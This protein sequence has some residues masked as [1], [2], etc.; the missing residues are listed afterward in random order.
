MGDSLQ[1]SA[2]YCHH[3]ADSRSGL[4]SANSWRLRA[5][6]ACQG[7]DRSSRTR[8]RFSRQQAPV[9]DELNTANIAGLLP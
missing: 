7:G 4:T 3:V 8:P 6:R 5:T 1:C 2:D 9:E